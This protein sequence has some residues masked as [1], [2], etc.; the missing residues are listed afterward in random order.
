MVPSTF[1][2]AIVDLLGCRSYLEI[3]CG[4]CATLNAIRAARKIGVDP[5]PGGTVRATSN[6][7]FQ[8]NTDK[9]DL[10]F[11]DGLHVREQVLL[12][13]ANAIVVCLRRSCRFARL[14]AANRITSVSDNQRRTMD[15]RRVEGGSSTA[16][17]A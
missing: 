17:E 10:I 12:D 5:S 14:P 4:T 16:Y 8:T 1:L 11:I 3:G 6:E 7:F 9:F 2:N 15:G 13:A